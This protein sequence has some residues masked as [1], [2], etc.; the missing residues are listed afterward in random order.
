MKPDKAPA[1]GGDRNKV[2]SV[3]LTDEEFRALTARATEVG[4][5]PS[6]LART[7]VRQALSSITTQEPRPET[8]PGAARDSALE[9]RLWALLAADLVSRIEALETWVEAH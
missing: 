5:G 6:T 4:V 8:A 2:L 3:R 1:S 7:Y 9:Q